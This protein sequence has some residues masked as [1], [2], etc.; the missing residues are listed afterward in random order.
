MKQK[1]TAF[2][3]CFVMVL[4]LCA[5]LPFGSLAEESIAGEI[6]DGSIATA[7]AGG[8]GSAE[9]PYQIANGAQ[10][11]L[12]AQQVN[13]GINADKSFVLVADILLNDTANYENFSSS[14]PK[15]KWESIGR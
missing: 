2:L 11:A 3:L 8:D 14:A 15:N 9:D 10:L 7:Y 12:M 13:A 1:L 4:S 6:W 5:V